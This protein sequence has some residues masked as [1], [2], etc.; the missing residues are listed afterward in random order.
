VADDDGRKLSSTAVR[1][2]L[3]AGR[4]EEAAAILGRPFAIAGEVVEG[5]RL[6]RTLGFPTANVPL[7]DYVRP[8]FGVYATRTR[9]PDGRTLNGV[10]SLGENPTVGGNEARLEA[11]LF[12]FDED[13][14]GQVIETD[15]I[16]FLRP[17]E[18]FPTLEGLITQVRHDA[19]IARR[20][21]A[22]TT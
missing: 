7:G 22:A 11:W 18:R 10:S 8:R 3:E 17:E 12:D 21:F 13:L 4:P 20:L 19:A 16:A 5:R 15:L 6:G 1:L 14:Y 9:V 2:A